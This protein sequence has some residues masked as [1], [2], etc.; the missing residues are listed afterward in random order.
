[1]TMTQFQTLIHQK[2]PKC[3]YNLNTTASVR[4]TPPYAKTFLHPPYG[5][6]E[7]FPERIEIEVQ[8]RMRFTKDYFLD[9][10]EPQSKEFSAPS[11]RALWETLLGY[12]GTSSETVQ[13]LE[14]WLQGQE[15][16]PAEGHP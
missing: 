8:Y 4:R 12:Y 6:L 14:G 10:E 11:L 1:M 5:K 9:R 13:E 3:Q 7:S 2:F 15:Q 16:P